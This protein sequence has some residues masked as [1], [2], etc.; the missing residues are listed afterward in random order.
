MEDGDIICL[1]T[2]DFL[3]PPLLNSF[4]QIPTS[5]AVDND[6]NQH[7]HYCHQISIGLLLMANFLIICVPPLTGSSAETLCAHDNQ[8]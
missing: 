5:N 3:F 6:Y 7:N 1:C 8:P 4:L 2:C